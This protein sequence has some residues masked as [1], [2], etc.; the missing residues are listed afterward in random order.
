MPNTE[1]G[2]YQLLNCHTDRMRNFLILFT[3]LVITLVRLV[4]SGGARSIVA[5]SLLI[6]HQLLIVNRSRWR[7]KLNLVKFRFLAGTGDQLTEPSSFPYDPT[8]N[9]TR[10]LNHF[11]QPL[12]SELKKL[13][14]SRTNP[15]LLYSNMWNRP[16]LRRNV[17]PSSFSRRIRFA[18]YRPINFHCPGDDNVFVGSNRISAWGRILQVDGRKRCCALR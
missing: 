3:H 17:A 16:L 2:M 7:C 13:F 1:S 15:C 5:E 14:K 9:R 4:G 6:K 8:R 12:E 10:N 18:R 11:R